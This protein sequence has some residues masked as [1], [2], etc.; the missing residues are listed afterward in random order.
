VGF[1]CYTGRVDGQYAVIH[2]DIP[3]RTYSAEQSGTVQCS[4]LQHNSVHS[5]VQCI[6]TIEVCIIM[7]WEPHIGR[8]VYNHSHWRETVEVGESKV[9]E[10]D[11]DETP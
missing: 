11:G 7:T 9:R 2:R 6:S 1:A 5:A 8:R 4:A 10:G 3:T